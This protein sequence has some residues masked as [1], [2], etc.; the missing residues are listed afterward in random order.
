MNYL[1]LIEQI[2]IVRKSAIELANGNWSRQSL[3]EDIDELKSIILE[4][5]EPIIPKTQCQVAS[6][7]I[8]KSVAEVPVVKESLKS[9]TIISE[10]SLFLNQTNRLLFKV[11]EDKNGVAF[12]ESHGYVIFVD[13]KD[14]H[15]MRV[16]D[17]ITDNSGLVWTLKPTDNEYVVSAENEIGDVIIGMKAVQELIDGVQ[18]MEIK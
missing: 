16:A 15:Y 17:T 5:D 8:E 7:K 12:Q 10:N 9:R 6:E 14:L 18:T 4:S 2:N 3:L 13:N 11:E 1:K